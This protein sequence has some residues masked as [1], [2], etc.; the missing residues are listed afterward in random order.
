MK[1]N[2]ERFS[3][4]ETTVI[5][6]PSRILEQKPSRQ[7]P[8]GIH[9]PD[10]PLVFIDRYSPDHA[11]NQDNKL[12]NPDDYVFMVHYYQPDHPLLYLQV[13]IT[14]GPTGEEDAVRRGGDQAGV[15][16]GGDVTLQDVQVYSLAEIFVNTKGGAL[17]QD[18]HGAEKRAQQTTS[19]CHFHLR[20]VEIIDRG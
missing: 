5:A 19:E 1:E 15:P 18:Q 13:N 8:K 6:I 11:T 12:D 16:I 7:M 3:S 9:D 2:S 17:G 4:P 10:T 20:A 14:N